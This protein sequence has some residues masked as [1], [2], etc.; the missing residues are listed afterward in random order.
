M[1]IYGIHVSIHLNAAP[2][3]MKWGIVCNISMP[4]ILQMFTRYRN[5]LFFMYSL[6][7]F[8]LQSTKPEFRCQKIQLQEVKQVFIICT[9]QG[10]GGSEGNF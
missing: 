10:P 8:I 1:F 9:K 2:I 7:V 4:F 3:L 6:S 5:I